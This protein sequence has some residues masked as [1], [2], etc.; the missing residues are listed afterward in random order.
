[1]AISDDVVGA[2]LIEFMQ[3]R[4][5]F[6]GSVSELLRELK[7]ISVDNGIDKSVLPKQPNV[8]SRK[9]N[10]LKSNLE[11][12]YGL[13]FKIKNTGAFREITLWWNN[14]K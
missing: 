11:Q 8:L 3:M 10:S 9:L 13:V 12:E 14:V 2:C 1:M 7:E 4:D 6:Q 5:S